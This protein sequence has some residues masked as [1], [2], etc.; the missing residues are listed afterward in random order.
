MIF[1]AKRS[2]MFRIL[3]QRVEIAY[4]ITTQGKAAQDPKGERSRI[5]AATPLC[6][7]PSSLEERPPL[8]AA[9]Y[10]DGFSPQ[11]RMVPDLHGRIKGV[12]V[13]VNDGSVL[14]PMS[15][16]G[17]LSS[18]LNCPAT[19]RRL[20]AQSK[21]RGSAGMTLPLIARAM[22]SALLVENWG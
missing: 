9:P 15:V 10:N 8:P 16:H 1:R 4:G 12:H 18:V 22:T 17:H 19:F 7:A 21:A 2:R 5:S 3:M 13:Q 11:F 20:L 6:I 14:G